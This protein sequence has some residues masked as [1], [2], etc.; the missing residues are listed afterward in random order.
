MDVARPLEAIAGF[1]SLLRE[2]GL[3]VGIAEQ[4]AM[5]QAAL[6]V[7][8]SQTRRLDAAWRSI[9]CQNS[10]QWQQWSALFE[11]YWYPSR[12]KGTVKTSGQ[13]RQA[14]HSRDMRQLVQDLQNQLEASSRPNQ[15]APQGR[16]SALDAVAQANDDM[17]SRAQG[18]ASR[19]EALD[20]RS[21]SQWLPQDLS[22]L[23]NLADLLAKRLRKRLTRRWQDHPQGRRL[24]IRRSC[25]MS[26]ATGGVPIR[27]A[28]R[29]P[30]REQPQ[31]FV[32]V[33]VSRSMETHAQLF[34]RFSRAF[35][36]AMQTRVFVFHTRLAEIT[37]LLK[38]DS[39]HVQEKINAVTAGFAGGTRIA[40]SVM[41]F[42]TVHARAQLRRGSLVWVFSDGYDADEPEQL[43]HQL[44][45]LVH[46][47]AR[48]DWFHP[49]PKTPRSAALQS[50][51]TLIRAFHRIDSLRDLEN[52]AKS[53]N[54]D[55]TR[56]KKYQ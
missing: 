13:T 43:A 40:T 53:F 5:V 12:I 22:R 14:R 20:D 1:A 30:R 3:Q 37:P 52:L 24:D 19:T 47:G 16:D 49:G 35:I 51:S 23:Q 6:V 4:Q 41:D 10:K 28:W 54:I 27:P 44:R 25:R 55:F 26:L 34:L 17:L 48:I 56:T 50:C 46:R 32:L 8:I 33:D 15:S 31:L 21:R 45:A 2:H 38:R 18:G 42:Q 7:P 9:A 11:R 29:R 36:A 39:L